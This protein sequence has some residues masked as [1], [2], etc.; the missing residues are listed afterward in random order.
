[1]AIASSFTDRLVG[2]RRGTADGLLIRS[3]SVHGCGLREPLRVVH[4]DGDGT[5]VYQDILMAGR[6]ASARGV[7]ILELP[8]GASGPD[9]GARLV[10]LPSSEV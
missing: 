3:S 8:I 2:V 10:V 5:V 6:R 9:T 4:L 1:M 7:W